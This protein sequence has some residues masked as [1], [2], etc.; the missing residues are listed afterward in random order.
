MLDSRLSNKRGPELAL[1]LRK[2]AASSFF[3]V[4]ASIINVA[5]RK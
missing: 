2:T 1:E 4:F 3:G 5:W